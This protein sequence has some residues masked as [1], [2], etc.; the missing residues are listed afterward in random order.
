MSFRP[1]EDTREKG[2]DRSMRRSLIFLNWTQFC[3]GCFISAKIFL[4]WTF[5]SVAACSQGGWQVA[6]NIS[7]SPASDV[8]VV[9]DHFMTLLQNSSGSLDLKV[10]DASGASITQNPTHGVVSVRGTVVTYQMGVWIRTRR[11]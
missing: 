11:E 7:T 2:K 3:R 1:S 10:G 9:G 8:S 5:F 6:D 4:I